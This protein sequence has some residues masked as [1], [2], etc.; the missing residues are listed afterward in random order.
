MWPSRIATAS[1]LV[2]LALLTISSAALSASSVSAT[3]GTPRGSGAELTATGLPAGGSATSGTWQEFQHDTSNSGNSSNSAVNPAVDWNDSLPAFTNG[4]TAPFVA[5]P[6]AG[7]GMVFLPVGDTVNAYYENN[8]TLAWSTSLEGG[9]GV[10]VVSTPLLWR[11]ILVVGGNSGMD[12]FGGAGTNDLY[13]LNATT[14]TIEQTV[15]PGQLNW[16]G[17]SL[18]GSAVPLGGNDFLGDAGFEAADLCGNVF[19]FDWS[20]TALTAVGTEGH[21]HGNTRSTSS[22]SIADLPG[23]GWGT[24][25]LDGANDQVDGFSLSSGATLPNVAGYPSATAVDPLAFTGPT[26]Y[27]G[28]IAIANVTGNPLVS[29]PIGFFGDD[30]GDGITSHLYAFNLTTHTNAATA[31]G[32][33]PSP[34]ATTNSG[35]LATPALDQLNLSDVLV[36]VPDLNGSFSG[37]NYYQPANGQPASLKPVWQDP[38]AAA[39]SLDA[40]PAIAGGVAYLANETGSFWAVNAAT[41]QVLWSYN[42][43]SP[44]QASPAL[45]Y[46]E[47]FVAASPSSATAT[48]NLVAFGPSSLLLSSSSQPP[49]IPSGGKA[50]VEVQVMASGLA[51]PGSPVSGAT[52]TA[53][54]PVGV[55]TTP[56]ASD[57]AGYS[58][59]NWTAPSISPVWYNESIDLSVAASGFATRATT[60]VVE[61]SPKSGTQSQPME[62]AIS[63]QSATVLAGATE[64]LTLTATSS[65]APLVGA[66]VTFSVASGPGSIA[67]PTVTSNVN[68]VAWANFTAPASLAQATASLV[69]ATATLSGYTS[70]TAAT[71]LSLEP[72][73]TPPPSN[74]YALTVAASPQ[75]LSVLSGESGDLSITLENSSVPVAGLSVS[76]TLSSATE[77]SFSSATVATG[78]NGVAAFVFDATTVG[79]VLATFSVSTA[80]TH[81][82]APTASASIEVVTP[83]S[84]GAPGWVNVT[85][86][87]SS[88]T[89]QVFIAGAAVSESSGVYSASSSPGIVS[90]KVVAPGYATYFNNVTVVAGTGTDLAVALQALPSAPGSSSASSSSGISSLEYYLLL[91]VIVILVVGLLVTLL[92]TRR[93]RTPLPA[94]GAVG[95]AAVGASTAA[96]A[97]STSPT[98]SAAEPPAETPSS[99]S[100]EAPSTPSNEEDTSPISV[101]EPKEPDT[102]GSGPAEEAPAPQAT[103]GEGPA[104]D[105]PPAHAD[106]PGS[107]DPSPTA[108]DDLGRGE[109][110][111]SEGGSPPDPERPGPSDAADAPEPDAPAGG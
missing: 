74:T 1:C 107:S 106:A 41:G 100:A 93:R 109:N 94:P 84:S 67:V 19:T 88:A 63:P 28:S 23:V 22:P 48:G 17:R 69:E 72:T 103:A 59:L 71:A 20:G 66:S 91:A 83:S 76:A 95:G 60:A 98:T 4:G 36:V 5:S 70:A 82:T 86:S 101:E 40:S 77:G 96:A 104:E 2:L 55:L 34:S 90:V 75:A 47:A 27:T 56:T 38:L 9:V 15:A 79:V 65:S 73:T 52:V 102:P 31:V 33:L 92:Y 80:G 6:V 16:E 39:G 25:I 14:G 57:A 62:V 58:Y 45:A 44:V 97:P 18:A 64:E 10:S 50:M 111:P 11:G 53:T 61:V 87:P 8:G 108:F 68:G 42:L 29:Y 21:D 32:D 26:D 51:P 43:G 3:P 105:S 81:Y 37:W 30:A 110:G 7:Q 13:V 99:P 24:F 89:P 49:Q 54:T 46:G 35:V 85:V 12:C 78:S